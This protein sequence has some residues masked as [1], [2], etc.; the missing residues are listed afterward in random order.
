MLTFP[1]SNSSN[2]YTSFILSISSCKSAPTCKRLQERLDPHITT[3]LGKSSSS[4]V[5]QLVMMKSGKSPS[6]TIHGMINTKTLAKN[7]ISS[8]T[9]RE[10]KHKASLKAALCKANPCSSMDKA[11]SQ[12]DAPFSLDK[13]RVRCKFANK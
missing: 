12:E 13:E 11:E 5:S 9:R 6:R 3:H 8:Q 1:E 4:E 10:H 2:I 7:T